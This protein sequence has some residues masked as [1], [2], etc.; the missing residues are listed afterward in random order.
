MNDDYP[1]F[2]ASLTRRNVLKSLAGAA[3]L[4]VMPQALADSMQPA[5]LANSINPRWYGFNL[6]DYFS[7][8]PD[9]MKYFPIKN[10]G[11]FEEN[12][13]RWMRDWGFNWVRLPMDYRFWTSATDPKKIYE[14]KIEPIDRAIRL[15]E[16]YGIHVNICLH[17][18][19]G[20]CILDGMD[21]A[22]T[23]IRI[24]KESTNVYK[25]PQALEAFNHQWSYFAARYKGIAN[26]KLSFNLVNEPLEAGK[27]YPAG[28]QDYARVATA[29]IH[30]IRQ[31]DPTRLIIT[32]GYPAGMGTI[33]KLSPLTVMQS[34][35]DYLPFQLTHYQNPWAR[36]FVGNV[37]MPTWPLKDQNGKV[38]FDKASLE[39]TFAPWA[40][41]AQHGV[42]IHFGEI[43]CDHNT[44]PDVMYAWYNDTLDVISGLR[45]GW[46]LWNFRGSFGI[47]DSNRKGTQYRD[48]YGHELD[49]QLL[50]LLKRKMKAA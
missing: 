10:D 2:Q 34:C 37:P 24:S 46:G 14:K 43:G 16:Q 13:F 45:S 5:T 27:S 32:D 9:W 23:G 19:P 21:E 17:R 18:A 31:K 50:D 44:P 12:D 22:V 36:S 25:E 41:L 4:Q 42:P 33:P 49:V 29:A 35:H 28:K 30:A 47:L 40:S 26:T 15:G 7:T 3:A 48:W 11:E 38:I 20:E 8:D 6:L 39:K 1:R